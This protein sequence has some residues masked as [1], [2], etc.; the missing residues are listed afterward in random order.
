MDPS[1]EAQDDQRQ[2]S[3]GRNHNR[4]SEPVFKSTRPDA[5]LQSLSH[6]QWQQVP[7]AYRPRE[8][9][10]RSEEPLPPRTS[11]PPN[12]R[13]FRQ[14][15]QQI[16]QPIQQPRLRRRPEA[17]SNVPSR[18][19]YEAQAARVDPAFL[20]PQLSPYEA[21][22]TYSDSTETH[23]HARSVSQPNTPSFMA[24]RGHIELED[25]LSLTGLPTPSGYLPTGRR[26]PHSTANT[27]EA[28]FTDDEEFSLFVQATAGLGPEQ[29]LRGSPTISAYEE[30]RRRRMM[31]ECEDPNPL[32]SPIQQTPTTLR[33]LQHMAQMPQP[34]F[35]L[36]RRPV[37]QRLVT[38]PVHASDGGL[39]L[40]VEPPSANISEADV[41]PI[42]QDELPGYAES[43]AQAQAVQAS[44]ARRRAQ[45]LARRWQQAHG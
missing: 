41:S 21:D 8:W 25:D 35:T 36:P 20:Y 18:Q 6:S 11:T 15:Q 3:R 32:V 43:Q 28:P 24:R 37:P 45:E 13:P 23:G 30:D 44:E 39:D 38:D 31:H 22:V 7:L 12:V 29:P 33:A 1:Y 2:Y 5:H 14:F 4:L 19:E 42:E 27:T 16:A 17:L 34:T 26:R 9:R 40:W 10:D